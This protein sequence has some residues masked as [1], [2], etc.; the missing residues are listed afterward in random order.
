MALG[1]LVGQ[2]QQGRSRADAGK[3][4]QALGI[5]STQ[6]DGPTVEKVAATAPLEPAIAA[7]A[8]EKEKPKPNKAAEK[9]ITNGAVASSGK[10]TPAPGKFPSA[11]LSFSADGEKSIVD[12]EDA[13]LA[14]A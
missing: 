6:F 13:E 4:L 11:R 14:Q 5:A 1:L 2:R 12:G 10:L 7:E 8:A 9:T 3:N